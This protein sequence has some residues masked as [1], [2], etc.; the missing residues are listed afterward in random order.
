MMDPECPAAERRSWMMDLTDSIQNLS[1]PLERAEVL[2]YCGV[3]GYELGEIEQQSIWATRISETVAAEKWLDKAAEIYE[4]YDDR[5][6]E[7]AVQWLLYIVQR[8]RGRYRQAYN[9]ARR[10]RRLS[11]NLLQERLVKKNTFGE[12]WYR[13]RIEDMTVDLI[14]SPEDMF[15]CLFEF[16]ASCLSLSAA[17]IKSRISV[18]VEKK[19]Y[20]KSKEEMQLLLGIT[21]RSP[22]PEEAAEAL[23]FCGVINWVLENKRDAI[24]FLRSAMT[25]YIPSSFDYAVVQWMLG[26][27]LFTFP[28]DVPRA[29]QAMENS[30]QSFDRQRQ[31]A[32]HENL[33]DR[34][35]WF[36]NHYNAMKRV[37]RTMVD[38][39]KPKLAS[40]DA[41][42]VEI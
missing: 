21:H 35:D 16:Q 11:T 1:N 41:V 15:E 3:I 26:L 38:A 34:A 24:D 12:S 6:R 40:S 18:Q 27:A 37:L 39:R 7:A 4:Y 19:E 23:A 14:S 20:E 33:M 2:V 36:V 42:A 30:I 31:K 9:H 13:G 17:E 10:S 8:G 5:H 28:S 29:I 32:I 22:S 25:Q